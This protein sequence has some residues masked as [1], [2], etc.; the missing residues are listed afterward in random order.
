V[1]RSDNLRRPPPPPVPPL[2]CLS[3]A[4]S[5]EALGWLVQG[6]EVEAHEEGSKLLLSKFV[7]FSNFVNFRQFGTSR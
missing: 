1:F 3:R 5:S 7:D 4:A 2:A 6:L